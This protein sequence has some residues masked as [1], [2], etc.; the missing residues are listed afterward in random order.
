MDR[1]DGGGRHRSIDVGKEIRSP[2]EILV[3]DAA[4][5]RRRIDLEEHEIPPASEQPVR[6]TGDLVGV[7]AVDEPVPREALRTIFA[8]GLGGRPF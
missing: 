2:F 1:K 5:E 3:D 4:R 8:A 7:R 6:D